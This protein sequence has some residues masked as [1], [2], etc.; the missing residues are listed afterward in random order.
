V[1]TIYK[2]IQVIVGLF[3]PS[4]HGTTLYFLKS[5]L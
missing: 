4:L 2:L 3:L 5:I 1:N